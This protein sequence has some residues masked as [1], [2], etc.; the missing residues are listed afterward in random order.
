MIS[1]GCG[2]GRRQEGRG[3]LK[4]VRAASHRRLLCQLPETALHAFPPCQLEPPAAYEVVGMQA[5]P[6]PR[7]CEGFAGLF[8]LQ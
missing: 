1:L 5:L 7:F 8:R 3:E 6:L 4:P 2:R